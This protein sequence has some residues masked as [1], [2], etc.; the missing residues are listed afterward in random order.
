LCMPRAA[1]CNGIQE[2]PDGSDE[3]PG[4]CKDITCP[5][6]KFQCLRKCV[7]LSRHCDG[8]VDCLD[9]SDEANCKCMWVIF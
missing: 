5:A 3:Q 1:Q 7:D 8:T 4:I 9:G 6:G 2:C